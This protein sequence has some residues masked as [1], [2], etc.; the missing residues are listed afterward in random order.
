MIEI[1]HEVDGLMVEKIRESDYLV[2]GYADGCKFPD[3]FEWVMLVLIDGILATFKGFLHS[4]G[5]HVTLNQARSVDNFLKSVGC[6]KLIYEREKNGI[7]VNVTRK[8]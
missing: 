1:V 8:L 7:M 2:R 4:H 6:K 3:E 5:G